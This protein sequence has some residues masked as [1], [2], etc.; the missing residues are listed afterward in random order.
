M[1]SH[2]AR[3]TVVTGAS[4]Y[5]GG[6]VAAA[7]LNGIGRCKLDD[8]P[9]AALEMFIQAEVA[10]FGSRIEVARALYLKAQALEKLGGER[11]LQMARKA[12]EELREF[13]PG[14][15]WASK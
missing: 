8:D 1:P 2:G 13:Y 5:V 12:R 3:A 7:I 14:S 4:G 9:R 6:L 11:N 10:H 15:R